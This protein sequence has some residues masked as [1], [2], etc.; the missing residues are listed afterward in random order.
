MTTLKK[1]FSFD[2]RDIFKRVAGALN[3]RGIA[4]ESG[5]AA[6]S[7]P[8]HITLPNLKTRMNQEEILLMRFFFQHEQ[9]HIMFS[10]FNHLT[11]MIHQM[12]NN[13]AY[14]ISKAVVNALEDI[15]IEACMMHKYRGTGAIF[16]LGRPLAF[17][18][19]DAAG[20]TDDPATLMHRQIIE[21]IYGGHYLPARY[22]AANPLCPLMASFDSDIDSISES[23]SMHDLETLAWRIAE[24]L[25]TEAGSPE[26]HESDQTMKGDD[27]SARYPSIT[28]GGIS[29]AAIRGLQSDEEGGIVSD[30]VQSELAEESKGSYGYSETG[31]IADRHDAEEG[32]K[33]YEWGVQRAGLAGP[34]IERFRGLDKGGFSKPRM[35]GSKIAAGRIAQFISGTTFDILKKRTKEVRRSLSV[36]FCIDDSGSMEC[37]KRYKYAWQSAAMLAVACERAGVQ[38]S[39]A[40]FCTDFS[41]VKS[42]TDRIALAAP[43]L[44]LRNKGGT[45][46]PRGITRSAELLYERREDNRVVFLLTD[47][48]DE[49]GHR[50]HQAIKSAEKKGVKVIPV[51]FGDQKKDYPEYFETWEQYDPVILTDED[52]HTQAFGSKLVQRLCQW[53]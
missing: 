47:G 26:Y 52:A 19:W 4:I 35:S 24:E 27:R 51:L 3:F 11:T 20:V 14:S 33:H 23:T 22:R 44:T 41:V 40:R 25:K 1:T 32:M 39:V 48:M 31:S 34:L 38:I 36:V 42:F 45:Y 9:G 28:E 13:F 2:A 8:G 30:D 53:I 37:E 43:H 7:R 10:D 18:D 21:Y 50:V 6:G 49:G 17:D 5:D 15:R 29:G 16:A 12:S 46:I